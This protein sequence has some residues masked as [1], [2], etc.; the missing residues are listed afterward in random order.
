[1][2]PQALPFN[3]RPE[4][5]AFVWPIGQT[6]PVYAIAE[7]YF[8][9]ISNDR[10]SFEAVQ[11]AIGWHVTD[12]QWNLLQSELVPGS[13]VFVRHDNKPVGVACAL[14]RDAGWAE[15][16]WVAVWPEYRR[17][18]IGKIVCS[19]VVGQLHS[20]GS[21]K[22]FGSTQDHRLAALK[23]YLD[24]GFRPLV[25]PDKVERWWSIYQKLDKPFTLEM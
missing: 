4:T 12:E 19:A 18:G 20:L 8:V 9:D 5:V 21:H 23:I 15:L 13:M 11:A 22:I 1:M 6:A 10:L 17:Q 25:R 14:F 24:I 3:E 7:P 2:P 16:A